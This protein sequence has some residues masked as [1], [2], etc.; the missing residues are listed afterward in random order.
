MQ[1]SATLDDISVIILSGGKGT[2]IDERNKGLI[3]IHHQRLIHRVI[4]K[5]K[6][7][8][9]H[10]IISAND[11][12]SVY[13]E[14]AYPVIVDH[15]N[16]YQGPVSGLISCQNQIK[17]RLT[18]VVPVDAPLFP[19]DYPEKMLQRYNETG[20]ICVAHDGFRSQFLFILFETHFFTHL[21]DYFQ[22]GNRSMK[23][24]L[25]NQ[26]HELVDFSENSQDFLNINTEEDLRNA[27]KQW[28][29]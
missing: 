20:K 9:R 16:D 5:L 7:S 27:E 19:E 24:W 26:A 12:L 25:M 10:I 4:D 21:K 13:R 15:E 2:R 8:T 18:L 1:K 28:K 11:D 6:V 22:Q 17:T 3:E 23:H 29:K 14:F